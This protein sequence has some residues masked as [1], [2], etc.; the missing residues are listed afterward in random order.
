M[1]NVGLSLL[2][3]QQVARLTRYTRAN[4]CLAAKQGRLQYEMKL[5]GSN[6]A[7]LFTRQQVADWLGFPEPLFDL[8]MK[9]S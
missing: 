6:G 9:H 8:E 2:T 4:I 1:S 7:Y 5:P 3:S